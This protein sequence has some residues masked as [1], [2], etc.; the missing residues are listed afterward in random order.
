MSNQGS[1]SFRA[2]ATG[3]IKHCAYVP[4]CHFKCYFGVHFVV[5][6][7]SGFAAWGDDPPAAAGWAECLGQ[8]MF[9]TPCLVFSL[10]WG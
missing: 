10:D 5:V 9:K 4:C 3:V 8:A 2:G 1:A 7:V 6:I